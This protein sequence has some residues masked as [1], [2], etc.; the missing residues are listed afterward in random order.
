MGKWGKSKT[1]SIQVDFSIFMHILAY[2]DMSR[3]NQVYS[4]IFR[5]YS[6]IF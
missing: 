4:G 5:N 1:K 6:G 2:S 3:H